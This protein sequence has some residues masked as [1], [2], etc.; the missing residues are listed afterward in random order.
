MSILR[1]S[2]ALIAVAAVAA[3]AT[4]ATSREQT[5][6]PF[7][8]PIDPQRVQDQDDMTWADYKPI[9]GT[10]WAR[11]DRRAGSARCG[12]R[13]SRSTSRISR[14]SSRSR[15]DPIRSA[16]RRSIRCRAPMSRSSTPTSGASRAAQP[17]PHD[18]RV[19]DGTVAREDRHPEDRRLRAVP[20]AAQAVRVRPE[21]IQ[22]GERLPDRL[23]P[24]TAAW[25]ATPT[26]SGA[27][28]PAPT[29]STATRSQAAHLRRLRRDDRVAGIRRDEVREPRRHPRALGQSRQDQ[30]ALGDDAL[31][32]VDVVAGR[33]AAVGPVVGAAGRELGHD[34]A[35]ARSLACSA[36][37][38]TTTIRT[39]RRTAASAPGR[40][41]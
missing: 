8:A 37:A 30:A 7:P 29:S 39:S 13:S 11:S 17:R 16:I 2:L 41:T 18:P 15:R 4:R 9:P 10:N 19:L 28:T 27:P 22:P 33:R 1:S 12:S 38:T 3:G 36:S 20:H 6:V 25:S 21:R 23:T 31:R 32:A 5:P 34:H 35:R 40:G 24:A 26:R 14:S